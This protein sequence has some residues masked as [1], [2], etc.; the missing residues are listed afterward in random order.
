MRLATLRVSLALLALSS[1]LAHG[2][3]WSKDEPLSITEKCR[4]RLESARADIA[5][6]KPSAARGTIDEMLSD[7]SGTGFLEEAQFLMAETYFLEKEWTEARGEYDSYVRFHPNSPFTELAAYKKAL[8]GYRAKW[9]MG[10]DQQS[11]NTALEDFGDFLELY[12]SS[13][14]ADSARYYVSLLNERRAEQDYYVANL[15]FRMEED[16]AAAITMR[17]FL[18]DHPASKRVPLAREM[19]VESYVRLG[20]LDQAERMVE[21]FSRETAVPMDEKQAKRFAERIETERIK[22]QKRLAK[23][24]K[25]QAAREKEGL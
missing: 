9:V 22:Q 19:L 20:Q 1:G 2:W 16:Q 14:K 6:N 3:I 7:C 24:Q 13:S 18:N 4:L 10:R 8:S 21:L 23:E 15:Y 12:P 25:K 5:R 11:V 17:D